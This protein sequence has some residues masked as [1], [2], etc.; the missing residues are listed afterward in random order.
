[1][2]ESG[3]LKAIVCVLV[4]LIGVSAVM[5]AIVNAV[6]GDSIQRVTYTQTEGERVELTGSLQATPTNIDGGGSPGINVTIRN[7]NTDNSTTTGFIPEF[8]NETVALDGKNVTVFATDVLSSEEAI[9]SYEYPLSLGLPDGA[10][11][12]LGNTTMLIMLVVFVIVV[13]VLLG[14]I[15]GFFE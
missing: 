14:I 7:T 8:E 3:E 6:D 2:V 15:T 1:M 9:I 13:S 12:I 10:N 11:A 5:P 4:I